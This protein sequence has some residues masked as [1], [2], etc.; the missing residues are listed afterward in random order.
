M[1]CPTADAAERQL[2]IEIVAG[3]VQPDPFGMHGAIVAALER[4]PS[5]HALANVF[6]PALHIAATAHGP[7]IRT[8][9][10]QAIRAHVALADSNNRPHA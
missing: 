2:A 9:I 5:Q 3:A 8:T 4:Y 7:A 6:T 1:A 10:A